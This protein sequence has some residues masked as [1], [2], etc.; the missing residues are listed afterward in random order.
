MGTTEPRKDFPGL[1]AAFDRAAAGPPRPASCAS[2][3]RRAGARTTLG[4][5]IAGAAHRDRIARLGWVDDV[6]PLLAGAAVFAYPSRY[7]GFGL[8]PLEAM[9]LG[10]PVVATAVGSLPEVLGDAALLVPAG[11]SRRRWP[12]PSTG[13][14]PT[15][16][17]RQRLVGRGPGAGL[18]AFSWR[19]S[20]RGA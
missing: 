16:R 4:A 9:A 1:V 7:E 13:C 19:G 11:G 20:R 6:G 18:A 12:R 8:P 17:Y 5:A 3:G 14:S 2:P 10:V 15:M